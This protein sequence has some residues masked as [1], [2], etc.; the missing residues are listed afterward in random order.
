[1][2]VKNSRR[3]NAFQIMVY[4]TFVIRRLVMR[5]P[6]VKRQGVEVGIR[7]GVG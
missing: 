2:F 3:R 1:M 6:D 7:I 4:N 5:G